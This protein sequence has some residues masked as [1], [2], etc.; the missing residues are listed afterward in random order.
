MRFGQ[1]GLADPG[2]VE[3]YKTTSLTLKSEERTV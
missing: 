3:A 1:T 2:R